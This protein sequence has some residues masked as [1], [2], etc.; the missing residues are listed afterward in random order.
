MSKQIRL[1]TAAFLAVLLILAAAAP[2]AHLGMAQAQ[3]AAVATTSEA[4]KAAVV[5]TTEAVLKETS[6]LRQLPILR[7]VK[8]DTQSRDEIQR[9]LIKNMDEDTSPAEMH[10]SELSLKKLGLIPPDFQFRAFI[11]KLLTE[12]V[13]GY[14]DPK[15]QEFFLADW[16]NLDGQKPVMAHELTHAL[17]DQHFNLRRFD[18]WPKGD[19]D[20]ELAVHAL[21]E[22][23]ASLA[24]GVYVS[25]SPLRIVALMKS[26]GESKSSTEEIDRA[27]RALRESLLFPYDQGMQWVTQLYRREGWSLV[28]KAFTNLPQSTEQIL[29][30][31]KYF[32]REAPIKLS[33]PNIASALGNGW[34]QIDSDVN[35]EWGYYLILNEY[36]KSDVESKRATEG[37]GGDISSLYEGRKPGEVLIAQLSAWD[38]EPDAVEFFN[39]YAKRTEGRYKSSF[40]LPLKAGGGAAEQKAWRTNEG[41]VF[42]QRRGSRVLI[43][44]GVPEGRDA[45][46]LMARLW[47]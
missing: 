42:M 25:R 1:Q 28:S 15:Q 3:S 38:T 8:S 7:P 36:L 26:M 6:E 9:F 16:I 13:A 20:A 24:M 31:D 41:N 35:G 12:Q 2:S 39:A 10:A 32:A 46:A 5:E 27:P 30:A 4:K 43:L 18:K 33:L 45:R 34:K 44:E 21:I 47:Q 22:G 29:H 19:S 23:D 40:I 37:W 11:I 17:Q 14:Y